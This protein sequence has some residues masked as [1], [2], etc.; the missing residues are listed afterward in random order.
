MRFLAAVLA[1]FF[2]ARAVAQ[3]ASEAITVH[4]LEIEAVVVDRTGAP[5]EGLKAD[6]FEVRL[7]GNPAPVASVYSVRRGA[8]QD[9]GGTTPQ[10]AAVPPSPS[11]LVIITDDLHT[12]P[13]AKKRA[14]DALHSY[15]EKSMSASTTAML[16]RWNGAMS[17]KVKPTKER[18]A[19]LREIATMQREPV[20]SISA[21]G[22]RRRVLREIEDVFLHREDQRGPVA[23]KAMESAVRYAEERHRDAE[24]TIEALRE[25]VTFARG[26]HGRTVV[27]FVSEGVPVRAGTE[28]L[29]YAR[30]ALE[31]VPEYE[32]DRNFG[33]R[34]LDDL[35]FDLTARFRSLAAL[36]QSSGVVFSVLDP[37][38]LRGF[39]SAAIDSVG[40]EAR[41]DSTLVRANQSDGMRLV[42]FQTGGRFIENQ[43][44]LEHAVALLTDDV[45]SYYSIGVR[46]VE[47][48]RFDVSVRV[49]GREELRV[50]TAR[51]REL[52]TADD[53]AKGSVRA[54]LYSR[55][56]Q[57]P[58]GASV[59]TLPG[60]LAS[61]KCVAPAQVTIPADALT[62]MPGD[63]TRVDLSIHAIAL[64]DRQQESS[65]R[66]MQKQ[67]VPDGKPIV[68]TLVFGYQRRKYVV[69]LAIV[70]GVSGETSYLQTEVDAAACQ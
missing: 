44:D 2:A 1:V 41:I 14:L 7:S 13:Q 39:E 29:E 18:A 31:K 37:G 51:R 56:V 69:S 43:N 64:D 52:A 55:E 10:A 36:A 32:P 34:A 42:A 46:A 47:G 4:L 60:R 49:R 45:T 68:E 19:L 70:D 33:G 53:V 54:R 58:L 11:H 48:K 15:I 30:D 5:V 50:L 3:A 63:A 25:V 66:S 59:T 67:L 28:T 23:E 40:G 20:R 35:R 8:I 9:S 6:D 22:D 17:I 57:N 12:G 16:A 27:L 38:G 26:L 62:R 65:L 21:A 24:S 61:G